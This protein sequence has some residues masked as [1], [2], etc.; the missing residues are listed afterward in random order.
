[1][2]RVWIEIEKIPELF[3]QG[4]LVVFLVYKSLKAIEVLF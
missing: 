3:L 4:I 1:M 2:N